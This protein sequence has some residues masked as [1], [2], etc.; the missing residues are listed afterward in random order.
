[1]EKLQA[2]CV[3]SENYIKALLISEVVLRFSQIQNLIMSII[4]VEGGKV[5][6][7]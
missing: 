3:F 5:L 4:T 2:T 6:L 1:M 7:R